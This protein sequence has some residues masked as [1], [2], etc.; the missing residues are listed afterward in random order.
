MAFLDREYLEQQTRQPSPQP[1]TPPPQQLAQRPKL[2][3]FVSEVQLDL[4]L[5]ASQQNFHLQKITLRTN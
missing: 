2:L 1:T 5:I 3:A 4:Q